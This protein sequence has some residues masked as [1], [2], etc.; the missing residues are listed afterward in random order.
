MNSEQLARSSRKWMTAAFTAFAEGPPAHDLAVHHAGIAAEHILKAYLASLHP[1]LIVEGKD[2][3]S[4]L[5][6]TGHG[7][8]ASVPAEQVKTIGLT[9]AHL[10]VQKVLRKRMPVDQRALGPLANA[11][12]GVAHSG[13]YD[14]SEV[15]AVF[16]TC[17]RLIDPLLAELEIGRSY[18]GD[19]QSLHD[20]LLEESVVAVRVRLEGKLARAKGIFTER[21]G[22]LPQKDRELVLATISRVSPPGYIEHDEPATCPA[23]GS[24]GWLSGDTHVDEEA[25]AVLFTPFVFT[26]P[27]CDL[28]VEHEELEE[29]EGLDEEIKLD[30]SPEDFYANWEPDEDLYR[31]R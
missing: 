10:R 8:H 4:M 9:E 24:P 11:R 31:D 17:L 7:A 3:N 21:Y 27:A 23:C 30:E 26:C 19:Y 12:N 28:R 1:V 25:W 29:L 20:R 16:T 14:K 6:A 18:W 15:E 22:H 13:I 2:F 5:H